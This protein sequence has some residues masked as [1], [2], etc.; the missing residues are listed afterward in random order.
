MIR[1]PPRSTLF[2]YTTLFRS[3]VTLPLVSGRSLSWCARPSVRRFSRTG[4]AAVAPFD[5][6][7]DQGASS[8]P[9]P[10]PPPHTPPANPPHAPTPRP[11]L[12]LHKN[13]HNILTA[14]A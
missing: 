12:A 8:A 2:P 4:I 1:R 7:S 6:S 10:P 14:N 11:A 13:T 3:H 5:R 9:P